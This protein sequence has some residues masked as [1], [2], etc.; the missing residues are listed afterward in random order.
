[1]HKVNGECINFVVAGRLTWKMCC[2]LAAFSIVAVAIS[3]TVAVGL[4][5][6][7][8]LSNVNHDDDTF[9]YLAGNDKSLP[10]HN[11]VW[12]STLSSFW[13]KSMKVEYKNVSTGEKNAVQIY[14]IPT[15]EYHKTG[16]INDT[17]EGGSFLPPRLDVGLQVRY[18]YA[19]LPFSY[20]GCITNPIK[21]TNSIKFKVA[22]F[23]LSN[24]EEFD[25]Y[26]QYL[27]HRHTNFSLKVTPDTTIHP[28]ESKCTHLDVTIH[29]TTFYYITMVLMNDSV[30]SHPATY[31]CY[32]LKQYRDFDRKLHHPVCTLA[33]NKPCVHSF[34]N[35]SFINTHGQKLAIVA[36]VSKGSPSD[37][38]TAT[39]TVHSNKN[40]NVVNLG[41]VIGVAV[42][43]IVMVIILILLII[44]CV[45]MYFSGD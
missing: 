43:V 13:Y 7:L 25:R 37:E 12:L 16:V 42:A 28:G 3:V 19:H 30:V 2:L 9:V 15:H 31:S 36:D 18:L 26:L 11:L 6:A 8:H 44:A 39:V 32:S 40:T 5:L 10:E 24:K 21:N 45:K 20:K 22:V 29:H 23:R 35:G 38:P 34:Y 33:G 1:M 41:V 14:A 4:P 27:E 17:C